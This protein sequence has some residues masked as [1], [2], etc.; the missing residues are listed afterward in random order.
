MS[1]DNAKIIIGRKVWDVSA[2]D[3]WEMD[4]AELR[5]YVKDQ[6]HYR[7]FPS[8]RKARRWVREH[9][10]FMDDAYSEYGVWLD[11]R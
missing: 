8:H 10:G 4:D 1:S 3:C 7:T 2:S 6:P 9:D 5:A 11:E